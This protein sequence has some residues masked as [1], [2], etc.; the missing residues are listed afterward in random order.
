[1]ILDIVVLITIP[2]QIELHPG[3]VMIASF[4]IVDYPSCTLVLCTNLVQHEAPSSSQQ[5]LR[6]KR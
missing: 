4:W 3:I 1:V 2:S 5:I 6:P